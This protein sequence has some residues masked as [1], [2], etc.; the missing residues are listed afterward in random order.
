[1]HTYSNLGALVIDV[2]KRHIRSLTFFWILA[3]WCVSMSMLYAD[4]NTRTDS[5]TALFAASGLE[6][7]VDSIPKSTVS[8]FETALTADELPLLFETVSKS[9]VRGALK[10]A[11]QSSTF[12]GYL[13]KEINASMQEPSRLLLLNWYESPLGQRV[14]IAEV[15]NS[16]LNSPDRFAQFQQDLTRMRLDSTREELIKQIDDTMLITESA[17]DM[18]INV[19]VAFNMSLSRFVPENDRLS[20][21]DIVEM[22]NAQLA[23]LMTHYRQ[24][25]RELLLF[26]YQDFSN[27]ELAQINKVFAQDAGREFVKAINS[28]I[29]KGMFAASLDL[30]DA[31]GVHLDRHSNN[32]GI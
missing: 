26:T 19:Q 2:P 3:L 18:M 6:E 25:S 7:L 15:E 17:V 13:L 24:Q 5:S 22:A 12:S 10:S 27:E 14:R 9:E 8:S 32:P 23:Y 1:M 28:G 4:E 16:L 21:A 31:L 11:F 20:S 30:G 29:A